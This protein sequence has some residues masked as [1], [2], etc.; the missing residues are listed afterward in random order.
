L[1]RRSRQRLPRAAG[2]QGTLGRQWQCGQ[3][4][5]GPRTGGAARGSLPTCGAA[6]PCGAGRRALTGQ[7]EPARRAARA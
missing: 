2:T 6:G 3:P 4:G 1:A 7:Q 5:E